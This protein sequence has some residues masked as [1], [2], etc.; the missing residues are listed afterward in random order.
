MINRGVARVPEV[1]VVGEMRE[2]EVGRI[3]RTLREES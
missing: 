2:V 1:F 3:T